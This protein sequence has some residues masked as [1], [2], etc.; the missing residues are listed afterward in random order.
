MSMQCREPV[1]ITSPDDAIRHYFPLTMKLYCICTA[2]FDRSL[3]CQSY[4]QIVVARY[5][6]PLGVYTILYVLY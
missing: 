2:G 1:G 5:V 4:Y 6:Y 3:S